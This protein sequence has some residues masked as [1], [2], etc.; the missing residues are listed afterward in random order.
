MR[1]KAS[2]AK[3]VWSYWVVFTLRDGKAVRIEWF[4][5]RAEALEAAGFR[6]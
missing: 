6:D 5:D 3:V 1:G 4:G 2:G